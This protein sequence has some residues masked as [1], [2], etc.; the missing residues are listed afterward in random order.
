MFATSR[1]WWDKSRGIF[2]PLVPKNL[3]SRPCLLGRLSCVPI[4][5]IC[6]ILGLVG[7]RPN[8]KRVIVG[9]FWHKWNPDDYILGPWETFR[10]SSHPTTIRPPQRKGISVNMCKVYVLNFHE[11][12]TYAIYIYLRCV[13]IY[14][15]FFY[16]A[17]G[18][19]LFSWCFC[20]WMNSLV[21]FRSEASL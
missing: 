11:F 6:I 20:I 17:C 2:W 15:I 9:I 12:Y 7:P 4:G 10:F 16:N 13:R 19:K 3:A 18:M 1:T 21:D 8:F 5:R 14:I